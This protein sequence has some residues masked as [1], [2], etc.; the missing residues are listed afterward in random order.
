VFVKSPPA[1]DLPEV[2]SGAFNDDQVEEQLLR[3]PAPA[4][5]RRQIA[6]GP[7]EG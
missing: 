2:I 7:Q 4:S 6:D 3:A 5:S 1:N